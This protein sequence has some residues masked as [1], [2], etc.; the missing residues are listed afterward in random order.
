MTFQALLASEFGDAAAIG[1]L[2]AV[3]AGMVALFLTE[4][5]PIDL[6]AFLGLT[7]LVFTGYVA[8]D[9]AFTGFA[10]SAVITMLSIFIVSAGLMQTGVAD[11]V[12]GAIHRYV[13]SRE[14]PLIVAV[15][16]VAGVLSMFMN[17]IA[18]TAVLMPAVASLGRRAHLPPSRLF[19][20]L[21]FGAILGGTATLVGTP[22]NILAASM[23][24]DRGLEPFGLFDFTPF[25]LVML[26]GGIVFMLTV[27]R[28]LLPGRRAATLEGRHSEL[29]D[30]YGL[31]EG[32]FSIRI[33]AGSGFDGAPLRETRLGTTL[34]VQLLG[35]ARGEDWRLAPSDD[36]P[37]RAGDELVVQ[38]DAE[39]VQQTL[40]L[41][42]IDLRAATTLGTATTG[43]IGSPEAGVT[44]LRARVADGSPLVGSTLAATR[45]RE[46]WRVFV[47]AVER[48]GEVHVDRLGE[49]TLRQGDLVY[50]LFGDDAPEID[51]G[52][53]AIEK[54]GPA[55]L[56]R[57]DDQP[58]LVIRVPENSA[59]LSSG[60]GVGWMGRLMELTV[61]A[62][63]RGGEAIWGP[64]P[65]VEFEAG[66]RL[67]VKGRERR[68]RA[69]LRMGG[70][71][72]TSGVAAPAFESEE[73]GMAEATLA[74]RSGLA[75][76]SL[77][78][79][80]FRD[81]YGVQ[82]LAIWRE[83]KAIRSGLA[84]LALR[85]GDALLLQGRRGRLGLLSRERDLVV[86]SDVADEPRRLNKAP[87]AVGCLALMVALV[88]TG[89]AP[90]Q[91]AAFAAASLVVFCGALTMEE[92]YRA[93]EWRAIFL[94]AAILP[95]GSA[96]ESSGT[97]ALLASS[98]MDLAGPAGPY[99]VLAALVLLSSVL[100]Q[101]LDGAPA[102][103]L[104]T[105]VVLEAASGL[106]L[107][108]YPLMMGVALAA[109]A[110]FMTPFSHK[111]NLLVMGAGGYRS[112]DYL[113][114]GT[115]LTVV[116]LA[117]IVWMV[118]SIFPF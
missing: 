114:V 103:V 71:E 35:I 45:F 82:V 117:V 113:R 18:A 27:G 31:H 36:M 47:I 70:V 39:E 75:G 90:I 13:G 91:V 19:L 116:L 66:D 50:G 67:F 42:G 30:L 15:M 6:T 98:V 3:L 23:L 80:K 83:G 54:T 60:A 40:R 78:E 55:A 49:L 8:V 68:L 111:A 97:A 9:Q 20:P 88:V 14:A 29:A 69:L 1:F 81:R 7:V 96:M 51:A 110:A 99:A 59:L 52:V 17:N 5:L 28:R 72:L 118:P 46:R 25:G 87:F 101:C 109:S 73:V 63:E 100:S 32:L 38:G 105:P 12:G 92:A 22:P 33:P 89:L 93:V 58:L 74:P 107:S 77:A 26:L 62:V 2:L 95:V 48:A 44:A 41:Q 84:Q 94:V 24:R 37:L 11:L 21:A 16:L 76:R 85:V 86:L 53:L 102:V 56:D 43:E 10:S 4:K 79:T 57:L 61:V 104:L 106:G 65:G 108:P 115:P 64:G 112:M 34:G